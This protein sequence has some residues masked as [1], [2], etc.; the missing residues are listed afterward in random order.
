M[1]NNYILKNTKIT[2]TLSKSLESIHLDASNEGSE[3]CEA[4][5]AQSG[6]P[7]PQHSI[8]SDV[9]DLERDEELPAGSLKPSS[10]KPRRRN[11]GQD[12]RQWRKLE[13]AVDR[14]K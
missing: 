8:A 5:D 4:W 10:K 9:V 14:G 1:D 7:N 3:S 2:D 11:S 13:T 12:R 6:C